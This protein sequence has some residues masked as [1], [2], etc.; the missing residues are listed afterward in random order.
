MAS[1]IVWHLHQETHVHTHT[2]THTHTHYIASHQGNA[3]QNQGE[4]SELSLHTCQNG[5]HQKENKQQILE[6]MWRKGSSHILFVGI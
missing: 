3:N 4:M 1:D 5:Y 2:H 6:R